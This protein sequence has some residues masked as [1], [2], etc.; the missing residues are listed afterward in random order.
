MNKIVELPKA[1]RKEVPAILRTIADVIE[2]GEYGDITHGTVILETN[3]R[4]VQLF[5]AGAGNNDYYRVITNLQKGIHTM[6]NMT[7]PNI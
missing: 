7:D 5:C 2:R 6:M 4:E 3:K 1:E